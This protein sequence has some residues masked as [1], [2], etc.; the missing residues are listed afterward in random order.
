MED[1]YFLCYTLRLLHGRFL[2]SKAAH[3][4]FFSLKRKRFLRKT[5]RSVKHNNRFQGQNDVLPFLGYF[6]GFLLIPSA[7]PEIHPL[8]YTS[9]K[10]FKSEA[11]GQVI[12]IWLKSLICYSTALLV[13]QI[14]RQQKIAVVRHFLDGNP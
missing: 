4:A 8:S 9:R 2:K 12:S 13:R 6:E 14:G 7:D 3:Q 5:E 11:S 10:Y 1:L